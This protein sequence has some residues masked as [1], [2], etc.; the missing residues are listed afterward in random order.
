MKHEDKQSLDALA[1]IR[2]HPRLG[3]E[4]CNRI[5]E[6]YPTLSGRELLVELLSTTV[7]HY[8]DIRMADNK[9]LYALAC[10]HDS[11]VIDFTCP[12]CNKCIYC[13]WCEEQENDRH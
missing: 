8:N 13:C 5:T 9:E 1:F 2:A 6:K 4:E 3:D 10:G 7:K 11:R 12:T